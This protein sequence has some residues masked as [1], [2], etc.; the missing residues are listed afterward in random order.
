MPN[1][2]NF[3]IFFSRNS[4]ILG[5]HRYGV[6]GKVAGVGWVVTKAKIKKQGMTQMA[7]LESLLHSRILT[8]ANDLLQGLYRQILMIVGA[9]SSP[10]C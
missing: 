1:F 3:L 6:D 7:D 8:W 5:Q 4:L 10:H 9:M 2:G